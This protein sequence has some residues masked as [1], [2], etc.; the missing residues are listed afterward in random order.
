MLEQEY[1]EFMIPKDQWLPDWD[2]TL[3]I[4]TEGFPKTRKVKK[5]MTEEEQNEIRASNE[6][7]RT[8]RQT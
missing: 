6:L 3:G 8:E 1:S 4:S 7:I 2:V 5:S